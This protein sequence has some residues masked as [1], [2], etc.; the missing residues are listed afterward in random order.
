MISGKPSAGL[1]K[2]KVWLGK[3]YVHLTLRHIVQPRTAYQ[4]GFR[5][6][7]G[8]HTY[9]KG[10]LRK[11]RPSEAAKLNIIIESPPLI[12]H[13]D[14][15]NSVGALFS[16]RLQFTIGE[17]TRP[18]EIIKLN[19]TLAIRLT[20]VKPVVKGCPSCASRIEELSNWNFI[21]RPMYLTLGHHEFP[22][23]Y[24]F[25]GQLPA[26]CNTPLGG[27][28]YVLSAQ[29]E[30]I[31]G[32]SY[33][34]TMPLH[35]K[36]ALPQGNE[37]SLL[38]TFPRTNLTSHVIVPSVVHP[39]GSFPV[40][41]A[42]SGVMDK[43]KPN[44]NHLYIQNVKWHIKEHVKIVSHPCSKHASKSQAEGVIHRTTRVIGRNKKSNG[45]RYKLDSGSDEIS[46]QFEASI[47]YTR[48]PVCD[49]A[50]SKGLEVK[51]SLIIELIAAERNAWITATSS[52]A[53][54]LRMCSG[55]RMSER[56]GLGISWDEEVPPI[57]N[58]IPPGPPDYTAM[59]TPVRYLGAS[60][61]LTLPECDF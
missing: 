58:D 36:R 44:R 32:R 50:D 57:Y 34:S 9:S 55:L 39:M 31:V 17:H 46:L 37:T 11:Y 7:E 40:R 12:C 41:V 61:R 23:S 29:A 52:P 4:E 28:A 35:I 25:P 38:Y 26:F 18:I 8:I 21:T 24:L 27:I 10:H 16:G 49:V 1:D 30:D 54:V 6:S 13:G 56:S 47:D 2:K 59:E 43:G 48:E 53:I 15:T 5:Q 22:F 51:H 3:Y 45:S 14:P 33:S 42:L 20:T 60:R 19:L